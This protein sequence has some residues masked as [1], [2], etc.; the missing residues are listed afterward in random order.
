MKKNEKNDWFTTGL[1]IIETEGFMKI[2]IENLCSLLKVTKGSFYHH[3]GNID[4]YIEALMKYWTDENTKLLIEKLDQFETANEKKAILNKM[5]LLRSHKREQMIRGWSFSNRIVER[6]VREVDE[7]RIDYTAK[8]IEQCG[9]DAKT[10][11][12][13]A[14]LEYACMVGIQQLFPDMPNE[15]SDE[16]H[17]LFYSITK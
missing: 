1:R 11:K 3:F 8:L 9:E 16:L 13:I 12:Q 15:E 7:I 17:N 5:V 4:G 14:I 10:A 6:Y 2:T